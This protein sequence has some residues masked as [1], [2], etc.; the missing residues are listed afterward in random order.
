MS[1]YIEQNIQLL[2]ALQS[3]KSEKLSSLKED[4]NTARGVVASLSESRVVYDMS[5]M[6][7]GAKA[8]VKIRRFMREHRWTP[9][10][11]FIK[12]KFKEWDSLNWELTSGYP[13]AA[14]EWIAG[15]IS[16]ILFDPTDNYEDGVPIL[17]VVVDEWSYVGGEYVLY[18]FQIMNIRPV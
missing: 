8:E 5:S 4:N 16:R 14:P 3:D 11:D 9:A 2:D 10:D 6:P 18:P 13:V 1:S 15:T 12:R 17:T 7:P